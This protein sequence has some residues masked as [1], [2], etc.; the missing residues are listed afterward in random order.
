M[1]NLVQKSYQLFIVAT[2]LNLE[3]SNVCIKMRIQWPILNSLGQK[4]RYR[5]LVSEII[6]ICRGLEVD[7]VFLICK[8]FMSIINA[9]FQNSS[10]RAPLRP[11]NGHLSTIVLK[12]TGLNQRAEGEVHLR[13]VT[14]YKEGKSTFIRDEADLPLDPRSMSYIQNLLSQNPLLPKERQDLLPPTERSAVL[15]VSRNELSRSMGKLNSGIAQVPPAVRQDEQIAFHRQN[16]PI[17]SKRSDIL[18]CIDSNQV[19]VITG[20]TGSGK[21]TQVPQFILESHTESEKPCRVVC[22][23]PRRIAAIAMADRVAV[24]RGERTGQTIGFQIRLE[25]RVS[26]KTLLTFCTNGVLLRTLM[27][28]G[29]ESTALQGI[30]HIVID[31]VHER[32]H[33]SDFLLT[34]L[35]DALKKHRHLKLIVMSA[36]ADVD[37]F[38]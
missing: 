33:Y 36:T 12:N 25:S 27:G 6:V 23:E 11:T 19:T 16:L 32:D 13:F 21:T 24:E 37:L 9:I 2:I 3:W 5:T 1:V 26:P 14:V 35:R 10:C 20:E 30:T 28:G 34:I 29:A 18:H 31:E 22:C 15:D 8:K 38:M 17:W 7:I 4:S